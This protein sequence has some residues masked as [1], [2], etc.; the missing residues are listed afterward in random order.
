[1][2]LTETPTIASAAAR[3]ASP[4]ITLLTKVTR[5]GAMPNPIRPAMVMNAPMQRPRSS[6]GMKTV[7]ATEVTRA[8]NRPAQ[9]QGSQRDRK[10]GCP[11]RDREQ[12]SG[13][14]IG[15]ARMAEKTGRPAEEIRRRIE[16][17]S[18]QK[19]M[20]TSEEVSALVLFLCSDA[21]RGSPA[22]R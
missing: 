1:M 13:D 22:R 9:H 17:M 8:G 6:F 15:I 18:P 4:P 21:A 16:Q 3:L 19:R 2:T 14:G 11:R 7:R 5:L 20:V 10:Q 12:G